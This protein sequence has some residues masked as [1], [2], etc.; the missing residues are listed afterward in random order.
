MKYNKNRIYSKYIIVLD[1]IKALYRR[2]KAYIGVWDEGN[3]IKDL[4]KVAIL[5]PTLQTLVEK[6][7]R[8]FMV[9]LNQK[10]KDQK[11]NLAQMFKP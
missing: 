3:A 10:N 11:K 4:N 5:D 8:L 6:E 1:N 9:S 2:G 7:L